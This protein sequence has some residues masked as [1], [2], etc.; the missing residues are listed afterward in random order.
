MREADDDPA[1]PTLAVAAQDLQ[2]QR[3]PVIIANRTIIELRGPIAGYSAEER[4]RASIERIN[5]ALDADPKAPERL[6]SVA[7]VILHPRV[8]VREPRAGRARQAPVAEEI[9]E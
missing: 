9:P 4:A 5:A 8:A 7:E 3:A 1:E 2:R 6:H